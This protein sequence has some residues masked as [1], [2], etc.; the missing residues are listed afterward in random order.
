MQDHL[1]YKYIYPARPELKVTAAMLQFYENKNWWCQTKKNGTNNVVHANGSDMHFKTRHGTI[2][3]GDHR[4]WAPNPEIKKFF[5]EASK[6]G[7]NVFSTELLH[8]KTTHIKDEIYIFDAYVLDGVSL[9]GKTFA[10]RQEMLHDRFSG[11][12]EGDQIRIHQHVT[13]AKCFDDDFKD[14]YLSLTQ[15]QENEGIVL[16]NPEAVLKP[17]YRPDSNRSWSVKCRVPTKNYS[18]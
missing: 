7:W 18:F 8:N 4:Q 9:V 15:C 1:E 10:E 11:V 16:K 2:D 3:A 6:N 13:L 12:D 5:R 17:L 14:R